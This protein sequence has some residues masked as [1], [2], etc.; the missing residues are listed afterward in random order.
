MSIIENIR[1]RG[2]K[3]ILNPKKWV[4]YLSEPPNISEDSKA[5]LG[6]CEQVVYRSVMCSDC[7]SAGSCH[8]CGCAM[9]KSIL[10][11]ENWCSAG[12]WSNMMSDDEWNDY[13]RITNLKFKITY[14][15][16]E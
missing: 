8:H 5:G 4:A 3:D 16:D 11:K 10:V 9:P 6:Y 12:K 7:V 15:E 13:K 1:K 2:L 14:G